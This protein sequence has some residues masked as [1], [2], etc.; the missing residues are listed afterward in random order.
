MS[1]MRWRA[2]VRALAV[3]LLC[4]GC[5]GD[6]GPPSGC[7][8]GAHACA[9]VCVDSSSV[10]H[11][12]AACAPCP[13]SPN[14]DAV[15]EGGACGL[16]C[17]SGALLCNG[18]CA[19]CPSSSGVQAL[20][21]EGSACV[22]SCA[23]DFAPCASGCCPVDMGLVLTNSGVASPSIA[24]DGRQ[25]P[26][27]SFLSDHY[28]LS[29]A[30]RDTGAWQVASID[31]KDGYAHVG[32]SIAVTA[33]GTPVVAY[34]GGY[35]VG[36][37][38][39]TGATWTYETAYRNSTGYGPAIAGRSLALDR[40]GR[41]HVVEAQVQCGVP[42]GCDS[43]LVHIFWDGAAWRS[44]HIRDATGNRYS[45]PSLAIDSGDGLHVA[46]VGYYDAALYY[47]EKTTGPWSS[48]AVRPDGS[49]CDTA[50]VAVDPAGA[51]YIAYETK[52]GAY[53]VARRA[54]GAWSSGA[55]HPDVSQVGDLAFG[56]TPSFHYLVRDKAGALLVG[57]PS[58]ATFVESAISQEA[59]Q[60]SLAVDASERA[61][62]I[63]ATPQA[64]RYTL[65]KK[66]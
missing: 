50:Y 2:P 65:V 27:V 58:G 28:T 44:E 10:D 17:H 51:P 24:V 42:K 35:A 22:A 21:C 60:F 4:V 25:S 9:E 59:T 23:Q 3:V 52:D 15:C 57:S 7:P 29:Y 40:A 14:G 13:G 19:P 47:A 36:I 26:H 53:A 56:A 20:R 55:R 38:R 66:P 41:P 61:H 43:S 48:G 11:C 30:H 49:C 54:M 39:R 63:M 33:A 64:L 8:A 34:T 6:D 45:A 31:P 18:A 12:G 62:V 5:T 32:T 46:W 1:L 37:A 16:R